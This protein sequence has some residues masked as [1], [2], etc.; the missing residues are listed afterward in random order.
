MTVSRTLQVATLGNESVSDGDTS[1]YII[2]YA[3]AGLALLACIV[4]G[5]QFGYYWI[6]KHVFGREDPI[7]PKELLAGLSDDQR[8][9]AVEMVVTS[10]SSVPTATEEGNEEKKAEPIPAT[11]NSENDGVPT[12]TVTSARDEAQTIGSSQT[13]N[14]SAKGDKPKDVSEFVSDVEEGAVASEEADESDQRSQEKNVGPLQTSGESA[15]PVEDE[16]INDEEENEH[17]CPI[18]LGEFDEDEA[19]FASKQCSHKFHAQ[20]ILEWLHTKERNDCPVCRS[21]VISE[22]E[23]VSAALVLVKQENKKAKENSREKRP[24]AEV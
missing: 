15:S 6:C 20:C 17:V 8:S 24:E 9:T 23:M 1:A 22:E 2:P 3:I 11:K 10:R 7:D 13:T 21:E 18:C 4:L 16:M 19:V 5:G 12:D 14:E